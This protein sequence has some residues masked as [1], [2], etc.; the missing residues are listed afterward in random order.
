[1]QDC[2]SSHIGGGEGEAGHK[3]FGGSSAKQSPSPPRTT[4]EAPWRRIAWTTAYRHTR[5]CEDCKEICLW[6]RTTQRAFWKI[7]VSKRSAASAD[8]QI[9]PTVQI[10]SASRFHFWLCNWCKLLSFSN[11][12]SSLVLCLF[13]SSSSLLSCFRNTLPPL[14]PIP[15]PSAVIRWFHY[16]PKKYVETRI[17]FRFGGF[18]WTIF[19]LL[20]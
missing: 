12:L 18:D 16:I 7:C 10:A 1:M 2:L 19:A 14:L 5:H 3:T 20:I 9:I 11:P 17:L 6:Q 15:L 13:S 4:Q 8:A